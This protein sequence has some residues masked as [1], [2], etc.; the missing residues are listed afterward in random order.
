MVVPI[1]THML[2]DSLELAVEIVF[3]FVGE[4]LGGW[5]AVAKV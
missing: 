5:H 2:K 3:A 1:L 4:E